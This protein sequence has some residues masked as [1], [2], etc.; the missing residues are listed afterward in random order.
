[1]PRKPSA[2]CCDPEIGSLLNPLISGELATP[3]R[4]KDRDRF[5]AHTKECCSCR[6]KM[7]DRANALITVPMIERISNEKG[8]PVEAVYAALRRIIRR[9]H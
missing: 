2:K 8:L 7:L 3:E 5:L 4:D 1:M 9:S 6:E